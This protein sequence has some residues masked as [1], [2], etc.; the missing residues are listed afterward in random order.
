VRAGNFSLFHHI[1][2]ASYPMGTGGSFSG[3]KEV[4]AWCWPL[5]SF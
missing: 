3:G 2:S 1:R 5:T 4:R